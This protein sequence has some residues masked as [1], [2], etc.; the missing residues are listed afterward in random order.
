MRLRVPGRAPDSACSLSPSF[1]TELGFT[2][3]R[4][5]IERPKSDISDFG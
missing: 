4:S 5:L 1:T 3:V 2:R